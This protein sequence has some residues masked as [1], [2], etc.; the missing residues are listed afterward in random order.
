MVVAGPLTRVLGAF[1]SGAGTLAEIEARTG[2]SRDVVAASVEHLVR[3]GRLEARE[4]A[5]GC[6][7]G[8]CVS[9]ASGTPDGE[10]GCG[11]AKPSSARTGPVLVALTLRTR[12]AEA[13]PGADRRNPA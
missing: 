11:A 12:A 8:G 3:L 5:V 9:C 1:T 6:P 2:L 13:P 4:L 10:P 7:T